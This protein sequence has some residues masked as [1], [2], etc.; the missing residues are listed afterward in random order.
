M[1]EYL[2]ATII[3]QAVEAVIRMMNTLGLFATVTRG[4]L[5][6]GAGITCEVGPSV[7]SEV[8]LDKNKYI[9]LDLTI[10]G[11]NKNLQTL[12][13]AMDKIHEELTFARSYP[14]GDEWQIVDITTATE[15]Q[16][17]GREENNDWL[18]ASSLTVKIETKRSE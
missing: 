4:A 11:K 12:T 16:R 5:P 6:A 3:G 14:S 9:P 15:P 1:S 18:M 10:N 13:D 8:Y 17:I 2:S 7:P